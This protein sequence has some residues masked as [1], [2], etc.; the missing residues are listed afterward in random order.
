MEAKDDQ[1]KTNQFLEVKI[2]IWKSKLE[3]KVNLRKAIRSTQGNQGQF[4]EGK[5]RLWK[6]KLVSGRQIHFLEV[7]INYWRA[8]YGGLPASWIGVALVKMF[9]KFFNY[10]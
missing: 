9:F 2:K 10:F 3:H 6:R 1:W 7:E 5:V 4:M 8:K